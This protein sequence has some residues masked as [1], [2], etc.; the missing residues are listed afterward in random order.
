M[1][2]NLQSREFIKHLWANVGSRAALQL[3]LFD[4]PI[5][6]SP[7]STG[8]SPKTWLESCR[9]PHWLYKS[10]SVKSL[11]EG[12][13]VVLICFILFAEYVVD[14]M[15]TIVAKPFSTQVVDE[16]LYPS[17]VKPVIIS[18][19]QFHPLLHNTTGGN[20]LIYPLACVKFAV[21][22]HLKNI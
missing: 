8:G 7:F 5:I 17:K 6:K 11:G 15:I 3:E 10:A 22:C 4:Q 20:W 21:Y 14:R 9:R 12:R 16:D 2:W 19:W 1:L 13:P 18:L